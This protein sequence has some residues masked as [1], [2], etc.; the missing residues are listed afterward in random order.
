MART[1]RWRQPPIWTNALRPK[2]RLRGHHRFVRVGA[3]HAGKPDPALLPMLKVDW[4]PPVNIGGTP[5]AE[6]FAALD[7]LAEDIQ[8]ANTTTSTAVD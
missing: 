8:K 5:K 2:T 3:N 6:D 7:R 1:R 4:L